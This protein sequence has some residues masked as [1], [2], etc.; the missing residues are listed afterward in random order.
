MIEAIKRVVGPPQR[1]KPSQLQQ[2]ALSQCGEL[3][4]N[5]P[6]FKPFSTRRR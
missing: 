3:S 6:E 1:N 2:Y 5:T 4:S